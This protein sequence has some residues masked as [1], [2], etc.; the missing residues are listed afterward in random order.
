[1]MKV[2]VLS[3]AMLA[4][5]STA[6]TEGVASTKSARPTADSR[7]HR[8]QPLDLGCDVQ[9]IDA[10]DT[11]AISADELANLAAPATMP[12]QPAAEADLAFQDAAAEPG[13][14]VP[15]SLAHAKPQPLIPALVALGGL[16]ILLRRRPG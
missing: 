12:L 10:D 3:I 2:A 5:V 1:M 15:P 13:P 9:A 14:A 11:G 7:C 16:V 6:A 8:G 4:A